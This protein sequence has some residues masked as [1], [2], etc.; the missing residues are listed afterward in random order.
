MYFVSPNQINVLTPLNLETGPVTMIVTN[1]AA[2]APAFNAMVR[3][4]APSFLR[5][6][7]GKHIAATHADGSLLGRAALSVPGYGFAPAHPGEIVVLYATGFGLPE[8][9]LNE[10]SATQ[11]G[12]LPSLPAVR[13][14]GYFVGGAIRR[15]RQPRSLPDQ[16]D[17]PSRRRGRRRHRDCRV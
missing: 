14:R 8:T 4:A 9:T 5:F 10:G 13:I 7:D 17:R 12:A 15:R 2:S 3:A 16:R 11:F 6:A 1:G